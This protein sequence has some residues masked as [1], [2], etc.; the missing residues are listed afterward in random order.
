MTL[1]RGSEKSY[2]SPTMTLSRREF[3]AGVSAI[4]AVWLTG[5][6][7]CRENT[8]SDADSHAAEPLATDGAPKLV[9]FSA[10]DAADVEA[11]TARI[12]PTD[13][14]PGA[15][16]AGVVFF[17]DRSFTTFAADQADFFADGLRN[18]N[19]TVATLHP[20]ISRFANLSDEQQDSVLRSI[21]T[22]EFFDAIRFATIAGMFA[23][24]KYGGN[25]DYIGWKL[26][27]QQSVME[28]E[29]PFGWYDH[30]DNQRTL[31][32]RVL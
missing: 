13:E 19:A 14:T 1:A 5:A 29:P 18:L 7:S 25:K 24:P 28:Y 9:H 32:G 31:L 22:T 26:V 20:G 30:P 23:L 6:V 15:R 21:E 16:E 27:D 10:E 2:A 3:L 12:F 17:I 11:I 4:G 8:A